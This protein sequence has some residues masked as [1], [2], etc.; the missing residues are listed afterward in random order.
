MSCADIAKLDGR[1]EATIYK[2]LKKNNQKM[3]TRSQANK[4]FP[5]WVL[6]RMHNLGL[7]N[8]QVAKILG[9]STS[10]VTKRFNKLGYP[11]RSKRVASAI[12]YSNDEFRKFFYNPT[13]LSKLETILEF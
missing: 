1:S 2:I 10:T 7:S 9:I 11:T 12:K 4:I 3:R 13:F 8:S 5:D 6:L